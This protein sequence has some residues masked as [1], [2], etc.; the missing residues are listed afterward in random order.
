MW[1]DGVHFGVKAT[2]GEFNV[3]GKRG[4]WR[5]RAVRIKLEQ[6]LLNPGNLSMMVGVL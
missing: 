5:T 6:D 1:E 3:A 4:T 2:T